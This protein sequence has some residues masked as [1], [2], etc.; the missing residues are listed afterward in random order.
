MNF[1]ELNHTYYDFV[2]ITD[3]IFLDA[4]KIGEELKKKKEAYETQARMI[5]YLQK[6]ELMPKTDELK[7][8]HKVLVKE[9]QALGEEIALWEETLKQKKA[10]Y[11]A[12][13]KIIHEVGNLLQKEQL[14]ELS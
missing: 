2:H 3:R 8:A 1:K 11:S 5:K 7:K 9:H 6:G 14:K 4:A 12:Q 13:R 10:A